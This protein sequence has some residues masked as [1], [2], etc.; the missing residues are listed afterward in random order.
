[1][2]ICIWASLL[3]WGAG[4]IQGIVPQQKSNKVSTRST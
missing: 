1:M 4:G 2:T 3:F